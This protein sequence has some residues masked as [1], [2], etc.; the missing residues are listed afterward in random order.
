M[1]R[2]DPDE[3]NVSQTTLFDQIK[4]SLE[5]IRL[6]QIENTTEMDSLNNS[7]GKNCFLFVCP[8]NVFKLL[9]INL[10]KSILFI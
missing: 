4:L 7:T 3:V 2:L 5:S 9:I 1:D 6:L 8:L 10:F